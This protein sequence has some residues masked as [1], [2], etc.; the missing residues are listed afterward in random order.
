MKKII[1][2]MLVLS[3]VLTFQQPMEAHAGMTSETDCTSFR[4]SAPGDK[5]GELVEA[6]INNEN[7]TIKM[8]VTTRNEVKYYT[9]FFYDNGRWAIKE[10]GEFDNNHSFTKTVDAARLFEKDA[11]YVLRMTYGA[12]M[13]AASSMPYS[14]MGVYLTCKNGK[15]Y[16]DK[17]AEIESE[18]QRVLQCGANVLPENYMDMGMHDSMETEYGEDLTKGQIKVMKNLAKKLAGDAGAMTQYDQAISFHDFIGTHY[19]YDWS[20]HAELNPYKLY[21]RYLNNGVCKT[22]CN[23]YASYFVMLCRTQGIPARTTRGVSLSIPKEEWSKYSSTNLEFEH[24]WAE[25]YLDAD[26]DGGKEW[27]MF[28]CD[29]DSTTRG[30][31]YSYTNP[32]LQAMS[33]SRMYLG[34]RETDATYMKPVITD[35]GKKGNKIQLKWNSG[36]VR[37]PGIALTK[38]QKNNVKGYELYR[39]TSPT[40]LKKIRTIMT[41]A[42]SGRYL[43]KTAKSGVTYYYKV[44]AIAKTD[45]IVGRPGLYRT[46]RK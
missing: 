29:G 39:G 27:V 36:V 8:H 46:Y 1:A 13:E 20:G 21:M 5:S 41:T 26:G 37:I 43:D 9:M 23:G 6:E 34:Y 16:F 14:I 30:N 11:T 2:I 44:A 45:S 10:E 35:I 25:A 3:C 22:I 32:S 42:N 17:Y 15:L 7:Q 19:E 40:N 12:T 33:N 28:D 4:S 24:V 31:M 18:N 38:A